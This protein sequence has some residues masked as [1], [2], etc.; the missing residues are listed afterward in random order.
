MVQSIKKGKKLLI[1]RIFDKNLLIANLQ[2]FSHYFN[3]VRLTCQIR[4]F[5]EESF[6]DRS[7]HTSR[8]FE[9]HKDS[10]LL[11]LEHH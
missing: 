11:E 2:T 1:R 9:R 7:T 8:I 3:W 5:A 10:L 4:H 6:D